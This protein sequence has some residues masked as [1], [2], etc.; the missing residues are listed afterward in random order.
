MRSFLK[1]TILAAFVLGLGFY[2]RADLV[3][4]KNQMQARYFP[5]K[6]PISYSINSFD[7]QFGISEEYFKQALLD[8]E[9]I[10]EKPSGLDLFVMKETG[11]Q[12]SVN[13]VY[14]TRQATTEQLKDIGGT[15]DSKKD[16]YDTAKSKYDSLVAQYKSLEVEFKIKVS[17]FETR[18][19]QYENDVR[20]V[21]RKGGANKNEA[22]KLDAEK[23]YLEQE[24]LSIN[25]MQNELNE[26]TTR[27]NTQA[28]SLNKLASE[29]NIDVDH[30]N[31]VGGS[32]GRE[33]EEGTYIQDSNGQRIEIYQ[34]DDRT[35][36]VRVLAHELGHALGLDH[37]ED[38]KA[39][40]YYL[41]NG[42]NE[43]LTEG[44][45]FAL[46]EYCGITQ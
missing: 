15:V 12:V 5:C 34:F 13:L 38:S 37:I 9:E 16:V 23:K 29:L 10:W 35:K 11:G 4:L 22:E 25:N 1:N 36:L 8:A 21:N 17:N 45:I 44:D 3:L 33:F 32:L 2:F 6:Q 18:K 20:A 42:V 41:N 30:F 31:T 39:I 24:L 7:T 26:M 46:N 27:I 28:E 14:D 40:M 43:S 19:R